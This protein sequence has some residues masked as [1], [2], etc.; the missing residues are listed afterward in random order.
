MKKCILL[1]LLTFNLTAFAQNKN[2]RYFKITQKEC[3]PKK[4][5]QFVLKQIVSDSRCPKG[6]NC[7]WAGEIKLLVSVYQD[8]HFI[9]D[10]AVTIS[11]NNFQENKD[12]LVRYLPINKQNLQ[13]IT[14]FPYPEEGIKINPKDYYLKI[15][16]LK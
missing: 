14:V 3:L 16:Y 11:G 6:V 9:T 15:G 1:L 4:G 5:Y 7:I 13:T 12:W 10:E 2:L 8:K